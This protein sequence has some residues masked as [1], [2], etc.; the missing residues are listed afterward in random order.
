MHV[1]LAETCPGAWVT[2]SRLGPIS[3]A[4]AGEA[5]RKAVEAGSAP[6]TLP[7][8]DPGPAS[9]LPVVPVALRGG[10]PISARPGTIAAFAASQGVEAE[11]VYLTHVTLGPDCQGRTQAPPCRLLTKAPAAAARFAVREPVEA[12]LTAGT[13]PPDDVGPARALPAL[14]A[15]G[16]AGGPSRVALARQCTLVVKGHQGSGRILTEFRGSLGVN[17]KTVSSTI[18]DK[19]Q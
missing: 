6:V 3:A 1:F 9:A 19:L 7:P 14:G 2:D 17:I 11:G 16:V 5:L 15:A 10:G 12:R 18:G 4:V 13:L 8:C